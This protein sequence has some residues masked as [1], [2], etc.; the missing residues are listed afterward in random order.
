MANVNCLEGIK[1]PQ[2]GQEDEFRIEVVK[3]LKVT[4]SGTEDLGGEE[5]WDKDSWCHCPACE[6]EGKVKEFQV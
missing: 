3:T 2:C 4:D 6:R 1:C 5:Y